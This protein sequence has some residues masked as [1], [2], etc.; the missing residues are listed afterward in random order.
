[1]NLTGAGHLS[2]ERGMGSPP[3]TCHPG[4]LSWASECHEQRC[5]CVSPPQT[6][7]R[8]ELSRQ[9][10]KAEEKIL[11]NPGPPIQEGSKVKEVALGEL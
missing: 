9:I 5:R 3:G 4:D 8:W 7:P 11:E 1:M 6:G 2:E 10:Q